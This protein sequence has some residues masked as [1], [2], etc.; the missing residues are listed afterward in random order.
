MASSVS[1]PGELGAALRA[2]RKAHGL[3][4]ED[5]ASAAGV[6]VRF[7][8]E[9]ERGKETVRFASRCGS[10]TRSGSSSRSRTRVGGAR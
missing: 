7:L 9:L 1:T 8:S 10:W 3:R 2:A 4:L 6:G 5:V